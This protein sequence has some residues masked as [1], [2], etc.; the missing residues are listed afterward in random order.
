[1]YNLSEKQ[2]QRIDFDKF[3]SYLD[4]ETEKKIFH[5]LRSIFKKK[6]VIIITHNQKSIVRRYIK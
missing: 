1:M 3:R 5:N 6:I 2:A 4:I